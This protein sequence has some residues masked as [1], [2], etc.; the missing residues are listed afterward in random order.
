[1]LLF[2]VCLFKRSPRYPTPEEGNNSSYSEQDENESP[3]G[4]Q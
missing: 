2:N 1:M 3:T 4:K